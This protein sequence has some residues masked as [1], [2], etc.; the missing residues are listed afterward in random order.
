MFVITSETKLNS[1]V[2]MYSRIKKQLVST[3]THFISICPQ[4]KF[5]LIPRFDC[6]YKV[7]I[8]AGYEIYLYNYAIKQFYSIFFC[9]HSTA[10]FIYALSIRNFAQSLRISVHEYIAVMWK[11]GNIYF[12]DI[13]YQNFHIY[14]K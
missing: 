11:K 9:P 4:L 3:N 6:N 8:S 14:E 7:N 5:N 2:S 12:Y 13:F 1:L 10:L